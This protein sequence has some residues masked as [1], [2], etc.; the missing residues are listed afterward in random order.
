MLCI[1]LYKAE[2]KQLWNTSSDCN[3]TYI[4]DNSKKVI[5]FKPS[6]KIRIRYEVTQHLSIL[7]YTQTNKII[8][9]RQGVLLDKESSTSQYSQQH[10]LWEYQYLRQEHKN[11]IVWWLFQILLW[12]PSETPFLLFQMVMAS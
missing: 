3:T 6:Y 12:P 9:L 11:H 5:T 8:L 10:E 4:L 1:T 7:L 2:V